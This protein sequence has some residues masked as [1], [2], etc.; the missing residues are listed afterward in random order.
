M[1]NRGSQ[2][3]VASGNEGKIK[4][5]KSLLYE[6]ELQIISPL[7]VEDYVPPVEDGKD[8]IANALIKAHAAAK[9]YNMPAIADDSGLCC[10]ALNGEPGVL[11][12]RFGGDI[13]YDA[14]AKLL[15]EKLGEKDKSAYFACAIAVALPDGKAETYQGEVQGKITYPAE[16]SGGWGY[17]PYFIPED[18]KVSFA[19][20]PTETKNQIS[21]RG[22]ALAKMLMA[23]FGKK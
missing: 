5:L 16:S 23:I 22:R 11:T 8:F 12:A 1:I 4:E 15:W 3:F 19:S 9:Q 10:L 20:L 21:H 7:D 17:D 18:Y 2:V 13:S 6:Y 14:K